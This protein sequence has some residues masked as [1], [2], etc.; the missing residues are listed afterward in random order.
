MITGVI[1]EHICRFPPM[2]T[3]NI[4]LLQ[5]WLSEA[6][7]TCD[8]RIWFNLNESAF[9]IWK[10]HNFQGAP[11]NPDDASPLKTTAAVTTHQHPLSNL[12]GPC[13]CV[14]SNEVRLPTTSSR[15]TAVG[16]SGTVI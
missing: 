13:Y 7:V 12:K 1:V 9:T 8:I 11:N 15:M 3:H 16:D 6:A 2:L 10:L 5:Q 14:A 4:E